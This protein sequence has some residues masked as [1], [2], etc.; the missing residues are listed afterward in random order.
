MKLY[1]S[2]HC[3]VTV[4]LN[5]NK[6]DY[7]RL[8]IEENFPFSVSSV[9]DPGTDFP[10]SSLDLLS[11]DDRLLVIKDRVIILNTSPESEEERFD[12]KR[13]VSTLLE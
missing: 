13:I 5:M 7:E 10:E 2:I 11:K 6:T 4:L 3:Q 9:N 8:K 12:L 1:R